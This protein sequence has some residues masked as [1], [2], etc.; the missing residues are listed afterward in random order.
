MKFRK[1]CTACE[2]FGRMR[3]RRKDRRLGVAI[4]AAGLLE[5]RKRLAFG[6]VQR[7]ALG[8]APEARR[9]EALFEQAK[10]QRML[11]QQGGSFALEGIVALGEELPALRRKEAGRRVDAQAVTHDPLESPELRVSGHDP[12]KD[13][14]RDTRCLAH[15]RGRR[16]RV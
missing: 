11:G 13:G 3:A 8:V 12:R 9:L 4:L 15:P 5:E 16:A 7:R 2:G 10:D 14:G 6:P 1:G